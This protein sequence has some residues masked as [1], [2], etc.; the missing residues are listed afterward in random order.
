MNVQVYVVGGSPPDAIILTR[1]ESYNINIC[2]LMGY[3]SWPHIQGSYCI[4]TT[5]IESFKEHCE[6]IGIEVAVVVA[7]GAYGK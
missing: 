5:S 7:T 3:Q 6:M 4:E 2:E 1:G